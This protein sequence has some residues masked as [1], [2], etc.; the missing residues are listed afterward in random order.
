LG[1]SLASLPARLAE[2]SREAGS[3]AAWS[4]RRLPCLAGQLPRRQLRHDKFIDHL[5]E[6]CHEHCDTKPPD[7][8]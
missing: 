4:K 3:F 1:G 7:A 5:I 2:A 8:A 6:A